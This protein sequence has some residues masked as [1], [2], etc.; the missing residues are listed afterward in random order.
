MSC[1]ISGTM[2]G[3]QGKICPVLLQIIS[4]GTGGNQLFYLAD[5]SVNHCTLVLS[6]KGSSSSVFLCPMSDAHWL[7]LAGIA[8]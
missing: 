8:T 4:S 1:E 3:L 7:C 6:L 5:V 2:C